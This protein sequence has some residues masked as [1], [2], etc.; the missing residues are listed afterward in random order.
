MSTGPRTPEGKARTMAALHAGWLQWR[1]QKGARN[2]LNATRTTLQASATAGGMQGGSAISASGDHQTIENTC[3]KK[4]RGTIV[5]SA[6]G[7]YVVNN[8]IGSNKTDAG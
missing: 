8:T 3:G 6:I 2:E 4:Q 1:S 5:D 7:E